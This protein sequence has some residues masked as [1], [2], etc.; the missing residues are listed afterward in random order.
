MS[1]FMNNIIFN[2]IHR[3]RNMMTSSNVV[4]LKNKK[5]KE[6]R[7]EPRNLDKSEDVSKE[8]KF[9]LSQSKFKINLDFEYN[10]AMVSTDHWYRCSMLKQ[11]M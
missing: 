1:W 11:K 9:S 8:K 10:R 4:S 5:K 6:K 3:R 7:N 2:N